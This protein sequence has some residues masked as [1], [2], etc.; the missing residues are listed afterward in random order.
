MNKGGQEKC[1]ISATRGTGKLNNRKT[2]P[3]LQEVIER[4]DSLPES[5]RKAISALAQTV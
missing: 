1:K 5:V 2:D 3:A 4:W